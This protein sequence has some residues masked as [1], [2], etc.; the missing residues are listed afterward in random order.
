MFPPKDTIVKHLNT[1][2]EELSQRVDLHFTEQSNGIVM[3]SVNIKK[4]LEYLL[5]TPGAGCTKGE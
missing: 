2:K 1:K 5:E 4:Y 3:A